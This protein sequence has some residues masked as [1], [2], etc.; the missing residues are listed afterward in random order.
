[1]S[2]ERK[3]LSMKPRRCEREKNKP[4]SSAIFSAKLSKNAYPQAATWSFKGRACSLN[5]PQTRVVSATPTDLPVVGLSLNIGRFHHRGHRA[6]AMRN[7]LIRPK[8]MNLI[9]TKFRFFEAA[10]DKDGSPG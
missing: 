5:A 9:A 1:M 8:G 3:R 4:A 10:S 2:R 7:A 6:S